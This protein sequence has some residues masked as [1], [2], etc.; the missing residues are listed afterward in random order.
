MKKKAI[1]IAVLT[2]FIVAGIIIYN[3]LPNTRI[4]RVINKLPRTNEIAIRGGVHLNQD[5]DVRIT[6]AE[7]I[8]E[9]VTILS[10][11]DLPNPSGFFLCLG[12]N[13]RFDMIDKNG[14][15]ID[16]I[17]IWLNG[18]NGMM[19]NSIKFG[20]GWAEI[21]GRALRI[22]LEDFIEFS[23]FDIIR[24]DDINECD[25]IKLFIYE[26]ESYQYYIDCGPLNMIYI[27]F[28][29][30]EREVPLIKALENNYISI[31]DFASKFFVIREAR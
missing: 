11:A 26:D 22:A 20:C 19:P 13:L 24:K 31:E 2:I 12:A 21:D 1:G 18:F 25:D 7:V 29:A 30:D 3:L 27:R 17:N 23:P 9:I 8:S 15:L 16:T 10:N 4:N 14:E 6:D 5:I 28:F